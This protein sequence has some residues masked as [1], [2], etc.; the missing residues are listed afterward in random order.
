MWTNNID[1]N[2]QSLWRGNNVHY[3]S[4]CKFNNAKIQR[5]M[6]KKIKHKA[7]THLPAYIMPQTAV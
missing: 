7:G 4:L 3:M 5:E 6:T 2:I 1:N